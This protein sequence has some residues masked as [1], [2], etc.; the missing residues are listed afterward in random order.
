MQTEYV[1][2]DE[3]VIITGHWNEAVDKSKEQ[4]ITTW[5]SENTG[6]H[7]T[8]VDNIYYYYYNILLVKKRCRNQ[9]K[10]WR[11]YLVVD[12]DSDHNL[13]TKKCEYIQDRKSTKII[14]K[15]EQEVEETKIR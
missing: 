2:G 6:G 4:Q 14:P 15:Q 13:V 10:D 11:W 12:I 9:M 8:M 7:G 3:N 5:Y 1:E